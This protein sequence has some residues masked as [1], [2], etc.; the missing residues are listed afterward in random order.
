MAYFKIKKTDGT[1]DVVQSRPIRH[2]KELG[3]D[4]VEI[5]VINFIQ[6]WF[7]KLSKRGK[8]NGK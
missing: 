5:K 7:F 6:Y 8:T 1:F 3:E 4:C 2:K